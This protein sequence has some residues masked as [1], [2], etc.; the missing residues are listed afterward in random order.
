MTTS[1]QA[2]NAQFA[3]DFVD[4]IQPLVDQTFDQSATIARLAAKAVTDMG[5]IAML[6][7]ESGEEEFFHP[8]NFELLDSH[9]IQLQSQF[10]ESELKAGLKILL[11]NQLD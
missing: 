4:L 6:K 7:F 5:A 10:T 9:K 11:L 2:T 3:T 1:K 8:D